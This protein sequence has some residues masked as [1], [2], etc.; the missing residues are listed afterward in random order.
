MVCAAAMGKKTAVSGSRVRV[1]ASPGTP[2][3]DRVVLFVRCLRWGRT[4]VGDGVDVLV[5]EPDG[6]GV[7]AVLLQN[8][9]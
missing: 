7:Y 4:P 5:V 1:K 3:E 8:R 6:R 9:W 2:E